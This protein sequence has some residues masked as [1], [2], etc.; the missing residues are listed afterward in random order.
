MGINPKNIV[1]TGLELRINRITILIAFDLLENC[2][3]YF[4]TSFYEELSEKS[5]KD[6]NS[7]V[8]IVSKF[9]P[10]PAGVD[11]IE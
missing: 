11:F 4:S 8:H 1:Y 6:S 7:D 5:K 10:T 3:I 2:L 9:T